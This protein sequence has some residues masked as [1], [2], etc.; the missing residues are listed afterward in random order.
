M[1]TVLAAEAME[2]IDG[3]A[4]SVRYENQSGRRPVL[5]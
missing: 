3:E 4:D 1:A 2:T 5:L